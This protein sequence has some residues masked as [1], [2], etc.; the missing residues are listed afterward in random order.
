[1]R[2]AKE[3]A[4]KSAVSALHPQR[5]PQAADYFKLPLAKRLV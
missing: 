5:G 3:I 1:M 2:L 4:N